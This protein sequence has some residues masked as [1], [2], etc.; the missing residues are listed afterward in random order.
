MKI[1]SLKKLEKS[2][3]KVVVRFEDGSEVRVSAEQIA[4]FNL[5]SGREMP[6]DEVL[7]LREGLELS[8]S[9]ARA[10]R[11][12]GSR[13]LSSR[14]I[15]KR[16]VSKGESAEAAQKTVEWLENIGAVNDAEYAAM[17]VRHYSAKGYGQH[18]IK[19]ELYR[20]G[21]LRDMWDEALSG[22]ESTGDAAFEFLQKKLGG[23]REK[24][25]IRRA[26]D[27]LVRRGFGYDEAREALNRYLE[28]IDDTEDI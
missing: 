13:S 17:I 16:L 1:Q 3:D 4:D 25:E 18:R 8:A 6:D 22:L 24:S 27:A 11:I 15:E 10:L 26:S 19:D 7:Q 9:K 5:Y 21:I 2:P 12:L 14:E 23:S 28:N 20:R